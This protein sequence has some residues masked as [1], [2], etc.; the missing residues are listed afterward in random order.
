MT[1]TVKEQIL[2]EIRAN[3][4]ITT[5]EMADRLGKVFQHINRMC[6]EL[7]QDGKVSIDRSSNPYRHYI[8]DQAPRAAADLRMEPAALVS[9][10]KYVSE[11]DE[12]I[13]SVTAAAGRKVDSG[14]EIIDRGIPHIPHTLKRGTMAVYTFLYGDEFLKIGKAGSKSNPRFCNQHYH[15]AGEKTGSTLAKSI[16][17]DERMRELGITADNVGDWIKQNTRRI[18]IILDASLGTFTLEL[19]EAALHYRY[20]PRYE[21]SQNQR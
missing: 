11:F 6:R 5:R 16:L 8:S 7:E 19:V 21:G 4:G 15:A 1:V 17:R 9:P 2:D 10:C 18:D 14:Y 3:P 12:I 13:K 20:E